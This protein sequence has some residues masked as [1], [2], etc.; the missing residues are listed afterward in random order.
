MDKRQ[1]AE[2]QETKQEMG[3][4]GYHVVCSCNKGGYPWELES[5][6]D[7]AI[8]LAKAN[9]REEINTIGLEAAK[10][11]GYRVDVYHAMKDDEGYIVPAT[12]IDAIWSRSA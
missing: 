8:A 10:K 3:S 4:H 12:H 6:V 1:R 2:I 7:S 5:S 11:E 9:W